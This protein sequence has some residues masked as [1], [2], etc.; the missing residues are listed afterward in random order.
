V[1]AGIGLFIAGM[2]M[3]VVFI[4]MIFSYPG[5]GRLFFDSIT[6]R[7]F[8]VVNAL[9]MIFAVLTALGTLISDIVLVIV[10][11]RIRIE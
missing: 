2:L 9:V 7:D 5:I 4:E 11:P 1:A 6:S 10:D 8:A 3:G